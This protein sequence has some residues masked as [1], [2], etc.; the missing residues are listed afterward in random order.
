[1]E[2][3]GKQFVDGKMRDVFR[4]TFTKREE[5]VAD[6]IDE[7]AFL[8]SGCS[9]DGKAILHDLRDHGGVHFCGLC[10]DCKWWEQYIVSDGAAEYKSEWGD[11]TKASNGTGLFFA[12][13][14]HSSRT[15]ELQTSNRFGCVQWE[16]R[17]DG[18]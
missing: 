9:L 10:R 4:I 15:G 1:M 11:C 13:E 16:A 8:N 12:H 18:E 2:P 6:M 7:S 14:M 3:A 17:D 5:E